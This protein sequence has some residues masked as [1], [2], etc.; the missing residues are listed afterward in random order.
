MDLEIKPLPCVF[1]ELA[2]LE[3]IVWMNQREESLR[4]VEVESGSALKQMSTVR[5]GYS[6]MMLL[7][8][9]SVCYPQGTFQQPTVSLLLVVP[10]VRLL[11]KHHSPSPFSP[12]T[13]HSPS[14]Y[15]PGYSQSMQ[16]NRF[17]ALVVLVLAAVV[18]KDRQAEDFAARSE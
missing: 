10:S 1:R 9:N 17:P 6:E 3:G 11:S 18:V 5:Q 2:V 16:L 12:G 13:F 8:M 14:S 4:M 7:T 15:L